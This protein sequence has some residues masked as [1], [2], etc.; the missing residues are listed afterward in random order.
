MLQLLREVALRVYTNLYLSM[1]IT[2][3][4]YINYIATEDDKSSSLDG[5]KQHLTP[6]PP[7]RESGQPCIVL[8]KLV[9]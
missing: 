5:V 4:T 8:H 2:V 3:L 6:F 7:F 1:H 9:L